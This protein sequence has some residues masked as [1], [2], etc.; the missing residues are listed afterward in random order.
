MCIFQAMTVAF[1]KDKKELAVTIREK[2]DLSKKTMTLKRRQ[3]EQNRTSEMVKRQSQKML[4]M[5]V[6]Q[7]DDLKEEIIREMN[8]R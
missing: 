3:K 2:R 6:Q 1:E 4:E 8:V 5:L 7:Q